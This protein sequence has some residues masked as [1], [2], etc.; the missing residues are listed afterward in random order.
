MP[1]HILPVARLLGLCVALCLSAVGA[2]AQTL[3]ADD[4]AT[5][6][7]QDLL[8]VQ[9]S[10]A[11][12]FPQEVREAPASI[13]IITAEEIQR[14]GHR[15]LADTLRSV[16]G[17]Y[18]TYDRN[19]SYIGVRGF[20]RPGDY[21][22]RVLLL[23]DGHRLNDGVYDMAPIGT[24]F[25]ID[26][27]LIERV[28]V[29]RG[30]GSSLY[31]TNAFFAVINVV[32]RTGAARKGGRVELQGGSLATGGV[33]ASFG[34]LFDGGREL[35][36]AGSTYRSAGQSR[37][38][39]QEFAG[40][41][42][43]NGMAIGL[44]H[45]KSTNVFG[46]LS[47]GRL[48]IRGGVSHRR[49]QIPTA[50][51]GSVFGDDREFMVD[52]RTYV[53]AVYDGPVGHGWLGTARLAYDNYRYEGGFPFDY[54]DDGI[55]MWDDGAT[56]RAL[57]A[58]F[59]ARRRV[60]RTHM[61]TAG[62]EVRRHFR[63]QQTAGD[64][65]G[66]QLNV[67]APGTNTGIYVQDEVRLFR[68]LLANVGVR[69]DRLPGF[70]FHATPRVG[71]VVLPR[72]QTSIKVLH[73]RAFRAPNAYESYYFDGMRDLNLTLQPEQIVS[74]EIVWEEQLSRHVRTAVTAFGYDAERIIEQGSVVTGNGDDDLYFENRG[75]MHGIGFEAEV[76]T[77]L[78][79]GVSARFSQ[80]YVRTRDML[81]DRPFSNSPRHLLKA[82]VQVPV[83]S[84]FLGI[85][86]QFVG[87]RLTLQGEPLDGFFV[88]NVTLSSPAGRRV[89]F[90]LGVYNL[91][92]RTY[93]DPGGEEHVQQSIEQDGRTAIARVRVRF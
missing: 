81:N 29:I 62:A 6:S 43:T 74:S 4:V 33:S 53:S 63:L 23:I 72:E 59:T 77:K 28:E 15:T 32:T 91:F 66:E 76:E 12:K 64:V 58:E 56:A 61:F 26:V 25:P 8:A 82:A 90:T 35:L 67:D 80:T 11:S 30:P 31:G 73:G 65:Y 60:A 54:G 52:K 36:L 48:S 88:P 46:S 89:E 22:T 71:L 47:A 9:V 69:V 79:N 17:F 68:W 18:T 50:S 14:Y 13:T 42:A 49:K 55:V 27:S 38:H 93:S 39:Y 44:D 34:R 87:E 7:L 86:G 40:D 85:E 16:R 5:M 10:T 57:T 21:N 2:A 19:Y 92:D 83:S 20:S 75:H 78:P 45:D 70:G 3:T 24:D 41:G 84:F 1:K 51:F 37:L